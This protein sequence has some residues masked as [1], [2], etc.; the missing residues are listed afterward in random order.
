MGRLILKG[1]FQPLNN[2]L[3]LE[4]YNGILMGCNVMIYNHCRSQAFG[5]IIFG[6]W[7]GHKVFLRKQNPIYAYLKYLGIVVLSV[8]DDLTINN[9][10][11]LPTE[12]QKENRRI[13][14]SFYSETQIRN[15]YIEL[16]SAIRKADC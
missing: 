14:E 8:D 3:P 4:K 10:T 15:N 13:I 5:N 12:V 16:L 9:L 11:R 2:Y 7:T 6:I 1:M